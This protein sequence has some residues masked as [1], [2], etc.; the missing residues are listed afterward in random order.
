MTRRN[1][2]RTIRIGS[3]LV[4]VDGPEFKAD[5]DAR[6]KAAGLDQDDAELDIDAVRQRLARK[7]NMF[8]N[9]WP[10]CPEPICQRM[11]GCMA[12]DDLCANVPPI[13]E[14]ELTAQWPK[15]LAEVRHTIDGVQAE[16]GRDGG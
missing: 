14:E 5:Y 11:R 15:V 16:R 1:S 12:P 8:L 3:G 2:P 9:E 7:I 6:L 10:G 4:P 13:S